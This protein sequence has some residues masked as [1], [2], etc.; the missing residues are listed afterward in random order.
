MGIPEGLIWAVLAWGPFCVCSQTV[1]E[2][3]GTRRYIGAAPKPGLA[4]LSVPGWDATRV[5]TRA[6]TSM[7]FAGKL[8]FFKWRFRVWMKMCQQIKWELL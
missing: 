6:L 7:Q 1:G 5:P 8:C 4:G 3:A 2:A